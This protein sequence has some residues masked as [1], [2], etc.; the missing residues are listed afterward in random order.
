MTTR[1]QVIDA[2]RSYLNVRFH[3]QGRTR[4]GLDCVGLVIRVAHDLGLTTFDVSGYGRYPQA[5]LL[6]RHLAEQCTPVDVVQPGDVVLMRFETDPQHVAL[7]GD[8]R[9]GGLSLIHAF[10]PSRKVVEHQCDSL[11]RGRL[12]GAYSL[13]GVA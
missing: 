8:Y 12:L 5:D 1:A 6:R 11:W 13:P 2:A 4:A 9:Y 3:H 7:V 10:A